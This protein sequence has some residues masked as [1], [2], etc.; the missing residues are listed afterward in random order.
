MAPILLL[1]M[2]DGGRREDVAPE[3]ATRDERAV[4]ARQGVDARG[5]AHVRDPRER[6]HEPDVHVAPACQECA[7]CHGHVGGDRRED[8]F[9][10][11]QNRDQ[12]VERSGGELLEKREKVRQ[13]TECPPLG[14]AALGGGPASVPIA[15]TATPSPRPTH[16]MPSFVFAFTDTCAGPVR[17]APASRA[18]IVSRYG[19]SFGFSMMTVTS[20]CTH[21]NT[22]STTLR[23]ALL[24][25][26]IELAPFPSGSL[27]GN[28]RPMS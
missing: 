23:N 10:G 28:M 7:E 1:D 8:V 24:S 17:S 18:F 16:P 19:A 27:S 20:T 4:A 6:E 26:S 22:A 12:G 2:G 11:G 21:W 9:G 5:G 25:M 15:I 13:V 14:R 3:K